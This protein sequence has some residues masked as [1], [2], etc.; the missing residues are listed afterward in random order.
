VAQIKEHAT[1]GASHLVESGLELLTAVAAKR[2][3]RL[4]GEALGMETHED[5][6]V[7][8]DVTMYEGDDLGGITETEDVDLELAVPR[9]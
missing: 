7:P 4:S 5:G 1:L 6:F 3:K 2:A 8:G 9:W